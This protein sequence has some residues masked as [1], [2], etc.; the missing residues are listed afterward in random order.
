MRKSA[1][2]II[3]I[4]YLFGVAGAQ[5]KTWYLSAEAGLE[6]SAMPVKHL[7]RSTVRNGVSVYPGAGVGAVRFVRSHLYLGTGIYWL[8]LGKKE[9]TENDAVNFDGTI[10]GYYKHKEKFNVH[11]LELPLVIGYRVSTPRMSYLL[12][13]GP[14]VRCALGGRVTGQWSRLELLNGRVEEWSNKDRRLKLDESLADMKRWDAGVLLQFKIINNQVPLFI[15]AEGSWGRVNAMPAW[16]IPNAGPKE[17]MYTLTAGISLGY[18][19]LY[20]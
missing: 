5:S 13:A 16:K 11:Y 19:F 7:Y 4:M 3:F 8:M 2:S 10:A 20:K 12:G 9:Q 17:K 15:K 18:T 6:G 14:F 1:L